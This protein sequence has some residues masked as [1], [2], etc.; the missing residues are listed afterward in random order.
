MP[1]FLHNNLN[2]STKGGILVEAALVIPILTG[3][4]FFI[5]EVSNVLFLT[6]SLNQVA[7]EAC[8]YAVVTASYTKEDLITSSRANE[9]LPDVSRLTLNIDPAIGANRN[10]GTKIT[11]NVEYNYTPIIN[12]FRI[13][14]LNK[15]WIPSIKSSSVGRSEVSN[16]Q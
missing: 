6:N 15:S 16:A 10:A 11:V 5:V 3:I 14:N 8:R 1:Y 2:R 12:P 9:L 7:R 13:F 4:T